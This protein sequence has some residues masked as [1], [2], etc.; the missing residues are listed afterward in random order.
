MWTPHIGQYRIG[1]IVVNTEGITR[2]EMYERGNDIFT[3]VLGT[4]DSSGSLS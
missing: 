1:H 3:T 2:R 4:I